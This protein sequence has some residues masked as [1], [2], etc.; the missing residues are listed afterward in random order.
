MP[1]FSV[2][3]PCFNHATFVAESIEGVLRQS[4]GDLELIVVDDC[5]KDNSKE[6]IEK[7]VRIDRRVRA[8]Y[9]DTNLGASRSRNDGMKAAQSQ[10]LAF[11]DAD[12]VWLPA[13]LARQLELLE[14]HP[15]H[16]VAYSD[17]KI[18]DE[19]GKE[20]GQRFSDTFPVPGS[21]SGRL[22]EELCTRNF[23]NMQT[24][25]L[26]RECLEDSGYFDEQIKWVEDWWFWLTV[27]FKHS[28][29]YTSET[30]AQY[31]VHQKSTGRVQRR[32]YKVNRIKVFHR[33]LRKFPVLSAKLRSRIY[34]HIG[35]ALRGLG[36]SKYARGCFIRSIEFHRFNPKAGLRFFLSFSGRASRS[37]KDQSNPA[38]PRAVMSKP[39]VSIGLPVY[40]GEVYL[41]HAI[42]S[43]LDQT[44]SDF[45]LIIADNAS[46]DATESICRK[47]AA[48][49]GRIRYYRSEINIGGAGNHNRVFELANGEFFKWSAHDDLYPKEMLQRCVEVLVNA[50]STVS[51]VYSQFEW[52]DERG[53]S[54]GIDLDPIQKRDRRSHLRLAR[55]LSKVGH[56]SAFYGL[57][58][59]ETLRKTRLSGY[60]P[61]ADRVLLAELAMLGQLWEIREPLLFLRDHPGRSFRANTTAEALRKWYDPAKGKKILSLSIRA[62]A[63]LEIA[64]SALRLPLP[65]PDKLLC[66][67]VAVI[68]P[69]YLRL[70]DWTRPLRRKLGLGSREWSTKRNSLRTPVKPTKV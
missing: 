52:I 39:K 70:S 5:S 66:L 59:S 46:T 49:D 24:V 62:K 20:T 64:R 15:T 43:I 42:Q 67:A 21:G 27:S 2:I 16:K 54:L 37:V 55:L 25:V 13:K 23:I 33:T 57:I 35:V 47:F 26:R 7:Y 32:G 31:R 1:Q 30:L 4:V 65:L 56:H 60:F 69:F 28:F 12:D 22:F 6:V 44:Y 11:C 38:K 41:E 63:D 51:L 68:S 34:Y 9:H 29:V 48:R 10:Y 18:I 17:A 45:E 40:N 58:R 36:K 50:P 61:H 14:T 3:M 8:I 19:F 53:N